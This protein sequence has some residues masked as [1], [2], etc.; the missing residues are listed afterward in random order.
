MTC[1]V[2]PA[3]ALFAY[4]KYGSQRAACKALGISRATLVRRLAGMSFV[5]NR[6]NRTPRTP[7][8]LAALRRVWREW[9]AGRPP[10]LTKKQQNL[11]TK[12][13]RAGIDR[14][15]ARAEAMRD[16]K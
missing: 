16:G 6:G 13:L 1:S 5:A 7:E 9:A 14:D 2:T 12:L 15:T 3:Q 4:R 10:G 11:L 8:Q